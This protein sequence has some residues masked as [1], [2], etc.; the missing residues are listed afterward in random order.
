MFFRNISNVV[1]A[2]YHFGIAMAGECLVDFIQN[3]LKDGVALANSNGDVAVA[4]KTQDTK[5]NGCYE[6][7]HLCATKCCFL[8]SN[9]KISNITDTLCQYDEKKHYFKIFDIYLDSK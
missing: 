6:G 4:E 2:G 7:T 1:P 3:G 8:L 9:E 5:R